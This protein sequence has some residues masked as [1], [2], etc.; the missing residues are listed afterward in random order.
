MPAPVASH[1]AFPVSVPLPEVT[2]AVVWNQALWTAG[3][4]LTTGGFF[5]YFARELGAGD[6]IM[7]LLLVIPE[8]VGILALSTRPVVRRLGNR[9]RVWIAFSIAARIVSVGIPLLALV[10]SQHAGSAALRGLAVLLALSQGLGAIAYIAMLSWIADLV[11]EE[12]RGRFFARQQVAEFS[13]L[14]VVPIAGG[15]VVDSWRET[16]SREDLLLVYMLMFGAGIFLQLISMAPLLRFPDARVREEDVSNSPPTGSAIGETFRNRS[17]RFLILHNWWLAAANGMTQSVFFGF[18]TGPLGVQLTIYQVLATIPRVVGIPASLWTGAHIDRH[19][20]K[21]MMIAGVLAAGAA[22]MLFWLIAT[23]EEW[24]WVFGAYVLWG[25]WPMVNIPGR[26]LVLSL[27]PPVNN[28][29]ELALFRNVGGLIAGLSGLAGGLWLAELKE[30]SFSLPWPGS[31][32]G[33]YQLL[34]LVSLA[35]RATSVL[36]LLPVT[37]YNRNSTQPNL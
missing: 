17:L 18:L 9:K 3:Y 22:S 27:S 28:T 32:I 14:L 34:F 30:N 20:N 4:A 29:T 12:R 6:R 15:A 8:T 11:P 24:W 7:A 5:N 13:I 16:G 33:P 1:T 21:R 2:R 31:N 10:E 26:N 23:P 36:W 37:D 19:G 35:G 25:L